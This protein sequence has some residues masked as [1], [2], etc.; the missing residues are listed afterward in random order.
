MK[1]K[2]VIVEDDPLSY[3]VLS[4][5]LADG[6]VELEVVAHYSNVADAATGLKDADADVVFLDMELPDGKGFDVLS[7]LNSIDFEVII[8]TMHDSFMLEAIK[9]SA[10][11]YLMKPITKTAL[12]DAVD[13][14]KS[15]I[16]KV[17][18]SKSVVRNTPSNRLVIPNQDGLILVEIS[19]IIRLE[20]DGAYTNLYLANGQKHMTS[21]NLGFYQN[22]L[23]PD[24]FFRVHHSHIISIAHIK[25]YVRG[26]GGQVIMSDE[27]MVNVS[28]R[29]KEDFLRALGA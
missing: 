2:A 10:I 25:N 24:S 3:Q 21:K 12:H 1:Y 18:D 8:T 29:R 4:D 7:A 13:R 11:D 14:F 28:R 16:Q 23:D 27:S 15:R 9:H 17:S 26:E 5:V 6:F 22:Q 20:S 19:D